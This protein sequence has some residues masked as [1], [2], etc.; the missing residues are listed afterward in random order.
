M[1]GAGADLVAQIVPLH[2]GDLASL[3]ADALGGVDQLCDLAGMRAA[4]FR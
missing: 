3:A 4:H 2:A 1:T